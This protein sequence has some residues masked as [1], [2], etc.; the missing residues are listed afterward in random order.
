MLR[1]ADIPADVWPACGRLLTLAERGAAA[2]TPLSLYDDSETPSSP[3]AELLRLAMV[4]SV[5]PA[6]LSP[7]EQHIAERVVVYLTRKFRIDGEHHNRYDDCFDLRGKR[8][9]LRRLANSPTTATT[10]YLEMS[11]A[12]HWTSA[13]YALVC[14]T[15]Q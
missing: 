1:H 14:G 10:R 11:D 6:S 15:G 13:A 12:R 3:H 8:P 9:P 4:H 2:A 7:A 5:S